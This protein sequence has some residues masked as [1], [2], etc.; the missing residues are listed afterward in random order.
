MSAPDPLNHFSLPMPESSRTRSDSLE[1]SGSQQDRKRPRLSSSNTDELS[2]E[3]ALTDS[4]CPESPTI[5]SKTSAAQTPDSQTVTSSPLHSNKMPTSPGGLPSR[6]TIN[7][8]SSQMNQP[9]Q[10]PS[11]PPQSPPQSPDPTKALEHINSTDNKSSDTDS[12]PEIVAA[13]SHTVSIS[14]SPS[15]S[16]EIQVAELEDIDENPAETRW[17]PITRFSSNHN[18][19]DFPT[20]HYVHRTFPYAS[21]NSSFGAVH[22][23]LP[24]LAS[25][26]QTGTEPHFLHGA[27]QS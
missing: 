25:I 15:K 2:S 20:P 27:R 26:F 3:E 22:T 6:V 21:A 14:S 18:R 1:E 11:T 23:M 5:P 16:P 24:R 19:Q 8:R 17:T 12:A 7:T 4:G 9:T 10:Q 13:T